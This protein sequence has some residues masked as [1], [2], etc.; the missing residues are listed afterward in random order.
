LVWSDKTPGNYELYYKKSTDEGV[1][2]AGTKRLTWTPNDDLYSNRPTIAI[3]SSKNIHMAWNDYYE[4]VNHEIHY[5]QSSD[6]GATW[7]GAKRMT[8]NSG[9]SLSPVLVSDLNDNLHLVWVD[10]LVGK[11]EIHHKRSKDGGFA[12]TARERITWTLGSSECPAIAIDTGN[13][14]HL[15]W[16]DS[17]HGWSNYE[18]YYKKG[19]Q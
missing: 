3:D 19:I 9:T 5:K 16:C 15:V 1:T 13:S 4:S 17:T 14:I 11:F 10:F 7:H 2:W 12:W 6:G 18:I 8:W